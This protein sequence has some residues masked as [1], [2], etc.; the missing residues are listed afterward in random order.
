MPLKDY[1]TTIKSG[2][3]VAQIQTVLT[4]HDASAVSVEYVD[5]LPVALTFTLP[6]TL[7]VR[8]FRLPANIEGVHATLIRQLGNTKLTT[9]EHARD[10]GWRILL[11]WVAAQ[12]AIIESGMVT[13]AEVML[14]YMLDPEGK[15]TM[16]EAFESRELD[17]LL[18]PEK[19]GS[20]AY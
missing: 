8:S 17:R 1:R 2:R 12:M 15:H 5:R 20:T 19:A 10:V 18:L 3:T 9:L 6:T 13:P 11:D 16:Y 4:E 7:G 14:P